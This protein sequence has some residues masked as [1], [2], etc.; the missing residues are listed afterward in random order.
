M[1]WPAES[2]YADTWASGPGPAEVEWLE[3]MLAFKWTWQELQATP[4]YVRRVLGDL[5]MIRRKAQK[6]ARDR[7]RRG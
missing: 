5:L 6:D 1:L 3:L 7:E 2:I 4:P